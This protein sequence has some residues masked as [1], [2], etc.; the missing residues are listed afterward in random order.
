M[1]L[2]FEV[3]AN[4]VQAMYGWYNDEWFIS[5]SG[6][7]FNNTPWIG[8]MVIYSPTSWLSITTW[9]GVCGGVDTKPSAKEVNFYFA[10]NNAKVS[11]WILFIQY[12]IIHFQKDIPNNLPGI[13]IKIPL[14][15]Y[16]LSFGCDYSIRDKKPLFAGSLFIP[17]N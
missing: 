5:G 7:Y 17:L 4:Y 10:Y 9:E 14:D 11:Y 16:K 13:G 2:I 12:S 3:S 6:G 15:V 8:P 1:H